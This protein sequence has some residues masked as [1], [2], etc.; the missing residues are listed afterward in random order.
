M[1]AFDS[2]VPIN[3]QIFGSLAFAAASILIVLRI[4][5]IWDKNRI[6][7]AIAMGAWSSNIAFLIHNIT[8]LHST[9]SP[10]Q[11]VCVVINSESTKKNVT[12]TFVT[13]VVLLLTML[14]GLLRLR[15]HGNMFGLG[16][17]LWRQGL[18]WLFLATI[19]E[20]TPA[21][22]VFLNLNGKIYIIAS[23]ATANNEPDPFGKPS[24]TSFTT[25]GTPKAHSANTDPKVVFSAPVP[26]DRVEVA[27][28]TSSE[29]YPSTDM[30]Q[31]A[32]YG[33]FSTDS[34]S[35][36]TSLVLSIGSDLENGVKRG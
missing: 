30:S 31:C 21:V 2:S 3:C 19:A 16:K 36:D 24:R 33:Q 4:I 10:V 32:S 14:V 7:M 22:F 18:I 20:V 26:L 11:G 5:A 25:Y 15:L 34:Q 6:A 9:W 1:L 28:H 13:D 35:Q 23:L 12:A 8:R 27:I 29:E 17:F